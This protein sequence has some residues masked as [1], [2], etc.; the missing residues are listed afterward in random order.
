MSRIN[1]GLV[2]REALKEWLLDW[3]ASTETLDAK[4]CVDKFFTS[5]IELR[6]ANNPPVKGKDTAIQFFDS[7]FKALEMMHHDIEY[8]DF[9]APDHLYQAATIKYVVKGD[10]LE[11]DMITITGLM[12]SW[13][14]EEDGKLKVKRND[15]FLDASQ[16]FGRMAEKG[17]L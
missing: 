2:T 9:V 10:D 17:L 5:D 14:V 8:F 3:H 1:P 12:S 4:L 6:Y 15:I 13:L 7:A 11:R 16:V